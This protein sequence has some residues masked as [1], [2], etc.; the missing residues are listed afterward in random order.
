MFET[1][2]Q[3]IYLLMFCFDFM[4]DKECFP[5]K[6]QFEWYVKRYISAYSYEK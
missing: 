2:P 5:Q 4:D 6:G 1:H 3:L